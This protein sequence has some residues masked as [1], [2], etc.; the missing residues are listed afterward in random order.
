M[1]EL[2]MISY[3]SFISLLIFRTFQKNCPALIKLTTSTDEQYLVVRKV[4]EEH[5]HDCSEV[6][7][8]EHLDHCHYLTCE[9]LCGLLL[10]MCHVNLNDASFPFDFWNHHSRRHSDICHSKGFSISLRKTMLLNSWLLSLHANKKLVQKQVMEDTGK[11]VILKDLHNI[12]AWTVPNKTV[13]S[14]IE[15]LKSVPGRYFKAFVAT[16]ACLNWWHGTKFSTQVL[17]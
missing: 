16:Q 4:V 17:T 12:Q 11:V 9:G 10:L 5:N 8:H 1:L 13:Q 6:K 2:Q 14:L 7:A 3:F 15:A